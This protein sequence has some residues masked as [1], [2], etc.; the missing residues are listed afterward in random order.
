MK[1]F[2]ASCLLLLLLAHPACGQVPAAE[3]NPP[4]LPPQFRILDPGVVISGVPVSKVVIEALDPDGQL[5]TNFND[6]AMIEG[7]IIRTAGKP[8]AIPPFQ[9][10]ILTL[11]T[12]FARETKVYVES[13]KISVHRLKQPQRT[14][15]LSVVRI[16]GL[17]S[18]LP[19][20]LAIGVAV[21][22]RNV[23]VALF[24]SVWVGAIILAR[25]NFYAGFVRTLDTY[26]LNQLTQPN[27]PAH[28]HLL[29]ILF[30][31]FLGATIG[32]MSASG[33]T[34]A[35]VDSMSRFTRTRQRGQLMTWCLGMVVFFD[36]YANTM[37]VGTTMRPVTDRLK[38]SR[39][40]LS[41]LVDSTAAP[42][43]GLALISTWVGFELGQIQ[44]TYTILGL[45]SQSVYE[46]FLFSIPFRF[47]AVYLL[48]FVALIAI[49][50]H[51][52]GPMLKAEIRTLVYDQP[53][54]PGS[55][56]AVNDSQAGDLPDRSTAFN[57]IIPL[58]GL[59]A[60][61][62]LGLWF[63]GSRLLD[64]A[65]AQAV[66]SGQPVLEKTIWRV[67]ALS[68]SNRVLFFASF[69][70]SLVAM[71]T[72]LL[73]KSLTLQQAVEAWLSGAKSMFLAVV[74]LILAWALADICQAGQLNT[75][76][77]LVEHTQQTLAVQWVPAVVFILAGV[78]SLATGSSF[79][80]MGL[81]MPLA[82]TITHSKL[83]LLNQGDPSHHLM[84]AS[85]GAVLS[86]A[87]FG[88]HCSPISD[89]TVLSSAAT[90]CDHLDH[91]GTQVPYALT[92]AG[93]SLLFGYIPIGFG[94]SFLVALLPMGAIVML[95][96][97][98]FYGR[99]AETQANIILAEIG[100]AT[101][102]S[103]DADDD[104]EEAKEDEEKRQRRLER[105][106]AEAAEAEAK[107]QAEEEE[108]SE[109]DEG[110]KY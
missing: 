30:T 8:K 88:D 82:I 104:S 37:L 89:T 18:L 41:F 110:G 103:S 25:G 83:A 59:V 33:G 28:S 31:M 98:Q 21:W 57:A 50:G 97:I 36:D 6:R 71:A 105:E 74:I 78:I 23:I 1:T 81:L 70:A 34:H 47:Y 9:N 109:D 42:V 19:P 43:A 106:A 29:I 7:I 64:I 10:G 15:V 27:D 2:S 35:L 84:V 87:I 58:V 79:T 100:E 101:P 65:N 56:V 95:L 60:L 72:A 20:L 55:A 76:G 73:F 75:A 48:V 91:V 49:V 66:A 90:N 93:V 77:F 63:S 40:K 85:I 14:V 45:D 86:G 4:P 108:S 67:I 53:A 32:V 54:A 69:T 38:I 52:Y 17:L 96:I 62:L 92:V 3:R 12:D 24:A 61:V 26:L 94:Y 46:V 13:N 22:L 39:E 11:T 68:E 44:D 16:S 5:D 102:E 51:D 99:S 107:A 80:T